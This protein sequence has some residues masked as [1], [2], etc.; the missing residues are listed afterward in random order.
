VVVFGVPDANY[1]VRRESDVTQSSFKACALVHSGGKDHDRA[2]VENHLKVEPQISNNFQHSI[3]VRLPRSDDASTGGEGNLTF[4]QNLKKSLVWLIT[5]RSFVPTC[6]VIQ[7][8]SVFRN[9]ARKTID[10]RVDFKQVRKVPSSDK[11]QL[12]YRRI[13]L[14]NRF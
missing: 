9:D 13:H 2:L 4:P 6:G 8:S 10:S 5:K 7:E 11:N 3:L 1:I 12:P 14:V